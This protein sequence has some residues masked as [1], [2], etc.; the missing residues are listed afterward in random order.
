LGVIPVNMTTCLLYVSTQFKFLDSV[1]AHT[2]THTHTH[3]GKDTH[4]HTHT[5][6]LK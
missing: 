4:T 5:H 6:T 3:I 1:K 2:H